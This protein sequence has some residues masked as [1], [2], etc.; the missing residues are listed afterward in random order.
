MFRC[1]STRTLGVAGQESETI[2]WALSY[3]F[4]GIELDL[5][6]FTERVANHGLDRARRLVDSAKLRL[7]QFALTLD[8]EA[9]DATFERDR[10]RLASQ[11][12]LAA[13]LGC[14][15]AVTTL[16]PASDERPYHENFEFYRQRLTKVC[17][18]L[19][20]HGI[21][22]GVGFSA[23][24]RLRENK[25]FEFIHDLDALLLQLSMVGHRNVGVALDLWEL[26]LSTGA[27]TDLQKLSAAQI[28][29]VY[30]S[31]FPAEQSR[32]DHGRA[33]RL[34]PGET[35]VIDAQGALATL[36]EM[37]Y[38][39]PLVPQVS[40]PHYETVARDAFV[41]Q[42]GQALDEVWKSAGLSPS[43]KLVSPAQRTN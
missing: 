21:R 8:L 1:L 39:G 3:G 27:T 30:V 31:D 12:V 20:P 13:Q 34:L 32:D 35:G 7:A 41:K 38:D 36:A 24:A 40:R 22:L 37:G 33:I 9:D 26:Y 25:S 43:G 18:L 28:V 23:D 10:Q 4:K 29:S 5:A 42:V 19:E 15:R 14:T 11:I 6:E 2:E 16:A 17:G